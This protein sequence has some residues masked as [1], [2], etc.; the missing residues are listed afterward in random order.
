MMLSPQ[1]HCEMRDY[2]PPT[3]AFVGDAVYGLLVRETLALS[4]N[5]PAGDLH[6]ES[7]RMVCAAAQSRAAEKLLPLLT[8]VELSVYKRGRNAH[9]GHTPKNSSSSDYHAATGL[10]TLF[11]YL[12]L[13]GQTERLRSI[14]EIICNG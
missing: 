4:A 5:R 3:L 2:S 12:Y 13:C 14:F 6:A 9:T 1:Q 10:E 7:I 11:G 8:E